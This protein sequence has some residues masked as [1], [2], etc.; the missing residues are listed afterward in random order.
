MNLLYRA[1]AAALPGSV[2]A[3]LLTALWQQQ[4][5][6]VADCESETIG[7]CLGFG[8]PILLVGPLVTTAAVWLVLRAVGVASPTWAAALGATATG[9][10]A[11]LQQAG[12]P[13]WTPPPVWMAV[14][15]AA[16]GFAAGVAVVTVAMPAVIRVGLAMVLLAPFAAFPLLRRQ[17]DRSVDQ[18][19][20]TKL[21]LPLLIPQVPSYQ[22]AEARADQDRRLLSVTMTHG[23]SWISVQ[24]TDLPDGFAPPDRCGPTVADVAARRPG[25]VLAAA[26]GCRQV[27]PDHWTRIEPVGEVHLVRRSETVVLLS[28]VGDVPAADLETAAMTLTAVTPRQLS[29]LANR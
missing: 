18:E 29:L 23:R 13:G 17:T 5:R 27:G 22:I 8:F 6:F 16:A 1:A 19:A 26:P 2:G 20:F 9:G 10:A 25:Q 12:H 4:V 24:V 14:L 7:A 21:G 28:S 3:G 15:L 11:L